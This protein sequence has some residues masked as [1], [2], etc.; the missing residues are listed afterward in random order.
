MDLIKMLKA[1]SDENRLRIF[2]LL[3]KEELC[4]GDLET[5]LNM[6]QSNV[7]RHLNKLKNSEIITQ[8]KK[9]QW[10]FY[11]V[12]PSL[13][14]RHPILIEFLY[15]EMDKM[16]Q[17]KKDLEKL[18]THKHKFSLNNEKPQI[19]PLKGL[20]SSELEDALIDSIK[21]ITQKIESKIIP[22]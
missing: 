22:T 13:I 20:L 17:C 6:T 18:G 3:R 9:A 10:V 5:V 1:L 8:Q 15:K 4:V 12:N 2:N 7:S 16:T 21:D 11:R 14:R 19:P